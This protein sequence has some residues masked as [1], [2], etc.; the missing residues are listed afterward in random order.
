MSQKQFQFALELI[1]NGGQFHKEMAKFGYSEKREKSEKLRKL[2][3]L[4]ICIEE[5][6]KNNFE[7]LCSNTKAN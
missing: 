1:F 3:K 7:Y 4:N 6:I 2:Q 5:I